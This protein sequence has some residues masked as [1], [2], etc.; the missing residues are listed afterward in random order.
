MTSKKPVDFAKDFAELEKIVAWF[1]KDDVDL[2][3]AFKK[4]ETG[5]ELAA[6]LK[7]Y[8]QTVENRVTE[9]KKKF[10]GLVEE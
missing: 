4:F 3:E 7:E 1:E 6:G 8:L 9:I 2:E 10:K 5:L